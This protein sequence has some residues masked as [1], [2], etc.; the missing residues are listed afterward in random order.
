M[1]AERVLKPSGGGRVGQSAPKTEERQGTMTMKTLLL[2]AS[3]LA[4]GAT[5][6]GGSKAKAESADDM[7][8]D[9]TDEAMDGADDAMDGADDAMDGA[10]DAMEGGEDAMEGGDDAMEGGDDAMEGGE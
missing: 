5:A 6:C 1:T 4:F 7:A 8:G 9:A 10:D 3:L 2:L